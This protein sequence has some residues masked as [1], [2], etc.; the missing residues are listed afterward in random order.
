MVVV[1]AAEAAVVVVVV[2][3]VGEVG[4]SIILTGTLVA[5]EGALEMEVEV[6]AT[7]M[8][9]A[10]RIEINSRKDARHQKHHKHHPKN[11]SS[12]TFVKRASSREMRHE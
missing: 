5:A 10:I 2:G 11:L 3:E 7:D 1:V 4:E 9:V 12:K 8:V 6:A